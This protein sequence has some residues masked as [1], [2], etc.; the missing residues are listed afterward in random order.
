MPAAAKARR[1]RRVMSLQKRLVAKRQKAKVGSRV[2]IVVDGP[3]PDHD[4]VFTGRLPGQAP[5]IDPQV[6]LTEA[7]PATLSPGQFLDVEIVGASGYDLVARPL[8][9]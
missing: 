3:S 5:D 4:W 2:R 8:D 9:L 6:Y 1:L 7:D